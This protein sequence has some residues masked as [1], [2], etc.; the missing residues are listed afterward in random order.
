MFFRNSNRNRGDNME[1][2]LNVKKSFCMMED[3]TQ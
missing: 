3:L 1:K 2:G